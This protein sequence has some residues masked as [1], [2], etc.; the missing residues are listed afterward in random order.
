MRDVRSAIFE[1]H[2]ALSPGVARKEV[3]ERAPMRFRVLGFDPMSGSTAQST[4]AG[5]RGH[6]TPA[7]GS[8]PRPSRTLPAHAH[9]TSVE[10]R[11]TVRDGL[12]EAIVEDDGRGLDSKTAGGRGMAN[13]SSRAKEL[14]GDLRVDPAPD[15]SGKR[16]VWSVPV[17]KP[18]SSSARPPAVRSS[19]RALRTARGGPS[20]LMPLSPT[21]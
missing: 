14:G 18:S 15:G 7:R 9:A 1:L 11:V 12:L 10:V 6:R 3:L 21:S 5:R 19:H 13:L 4:P 16:L 8:T 2:T 20:P 17:E